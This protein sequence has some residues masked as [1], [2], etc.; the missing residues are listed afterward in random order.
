MSNSGTNGHTYRIQKRWIS[1][2]K[3]DKQMEIFDVRN[4]LMKDV[5]HIK[6]LKIQVCKKF[7]SIYQRSTL[8]K[9]KRR[10]GQEV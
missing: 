8:N 6:R 9:E 4:S 5:K 7:N 1:T 3:C 10:K 2:S